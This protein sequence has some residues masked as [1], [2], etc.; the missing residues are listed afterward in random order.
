MIKMRRDV[1]LQFVC[2]WLG[3]L[4]S[5]VIVSTGPDCFETKTISRG[6]AMRR[7][8][9]VRTHPIEALNRVSAVDRMDSSQPCNSASV[10]T[11]I[12]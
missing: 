12:T 4:E 2:D 8:G 9:R 3:V 1:Y 7:K 6:K 11:L 10:S 5:V